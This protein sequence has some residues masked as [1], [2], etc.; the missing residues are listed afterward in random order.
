[1][2]Q[3][4]NNYPQGGYPQNGGYPQG[5][6]PPPYNQ[7][8]GQGQGEAAAY[9]AGAPQQQQGYGQQG[10]GQQQQGYGQQQQG[11]GQQGPGQQGYGQPP[12]HH[13]RDSNNGPEEDGPAGERGVL[14]ALGGGIAGAVG[15]NKIGGKVTGHSKMST[16]LGAV[17]GAVAGHKLQDGVSDWKDNRDEE[18][19][20]KKKEEEEEKRRE[21]EKKRRDEDDKRRRE[22]DKRRRE[23]EKRNEHHPPARQEHRQEHNQPRDR[24]VSYAG[25][26]SSSARDTRLDAHGEYMLHT[27]CKRLD[28]SYQST[29]ISLNKIIENDRGSFRWFSGGQ[30]NGGGQQS[31]TVQPGDTLRA[32][33][34][35]YNCSFEEIAR[36][37]NIANPDLIHPGTV[38]QIPGSG[39]NN[40]SGR[41]GNFGESA[42]D[43]RL[44]DGGRRLDGELLRDGRWLGSSIILDERLSNNNGTLKYIE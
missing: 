32:I 31:H 12:Q 24:G 38:L 1:M 25:N 14:G 20:K 28:G 41:G 21:E 33:A 2:T 6:P 40:N 35:R 18:K 4:N 7:G 22:D 5:N 16:V 9:F 36:K 13:Q 11:Y 15:G 29:S 44:A 17:A 23:D 19:E 27:S 3:Y 42:R 10:Y 30:S 34:G 37:N 26:F 39:G 43:V 8:Q